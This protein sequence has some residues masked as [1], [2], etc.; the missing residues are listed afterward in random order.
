MARIIRYALYLI[1]A[2]QVVFAAAFSW[3]M[4]WATRLWPF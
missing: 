3:Q 2:V 1:A 4:P